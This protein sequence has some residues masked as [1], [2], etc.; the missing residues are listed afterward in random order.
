[1]YQSVS[2]FAVHE[3]LIE[4]FIL[5]VVPHLFHCN[6]SIVIIRDVPGSIFYWVPGI[7]TFFYRVRLPSTGYITN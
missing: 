1:V 3:A 5:Q 6:Y 2:Q 7:K 4:L